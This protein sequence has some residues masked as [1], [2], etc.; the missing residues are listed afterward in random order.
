MREEGP[1]AEPG[2]ERSRGRTAPDQP[3]FPRP[4]RD[5]SRTSWDSPLIT[6]RTRGRSRNGSSW[7]RKPDV[8]RLS[9]GDRSPTCCERRALA[10]QRAAKDARSLA[11]VL[12]KTRALR[13]VAREREHNKPL[14][15]LPHCRNATSSRHGERRPAART[16]SDPWRRDPAARRATPAPRR[17][18][19]SAPRSSPGASAAGRTSSSTRRRGCGGAAG[20]AV[21]ADALAA[22]PRQS[23]ETEVFTVDRTTKAVVPTD[24]F[25]CNGVIPSYGINCIGTY[26]GNYEIVS[27]SSRS[28]RSCATSRASIPC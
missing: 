26:G 27:G 9:S 1:V 20:A 17:A 13:Q 3:R 2:P 6:R 7:G 5:S 24:S 25:S 18:A 4:N 11:N 19:R 10:R 12:R 22:D 8:I 16:P 23:L 14:D 28:I 15:R 21:A